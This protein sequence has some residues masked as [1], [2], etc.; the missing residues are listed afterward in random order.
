MKQKENVE[1]ERLRKRVKEIVCARGILSSGGLYSIVLGNEES[2]FQ[3]SILG[4]VC[5]FGGVLLCRMPPG[6]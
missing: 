2:G 4:K 3:V 1:R 5:V 6:R